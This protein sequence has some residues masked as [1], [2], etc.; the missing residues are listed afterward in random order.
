MDPHR[1]RAG[2]QWAVRRSDRPWLP[3]AVAR[4]DAVTADLRR[5]RRLDGSELRVRQGPLSVAR[6]GRFEAPP[7]RDPAVGRRC[8]WR[9]PGHTGIRVRGRGREQAVVRGRSHLP[10]LQLTTLP[11]PCPWS[12][13]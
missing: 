10:L 4:P 9:R 1:R 12:T 3:D 2:E 13:L 6:A 8:P 5:E 11:P 7:R